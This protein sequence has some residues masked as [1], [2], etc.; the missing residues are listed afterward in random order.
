MTFVRRAKIGDLQAIQR[1]VELAYGSYLDRMPVPP[2]ALLRDYKRPVEG[3]EVDVLCIAGEVVGLVSLIRREDHVLLENL[4]V[5][6]SRQ[7]E[8]LGRRL[9]DH[10]EASALNDGLP[11]LRLYT[12][13][14]MHESLGFY[15]RCGF[16]EYDRRTED[17][18]ARVFLRKSVGAGDA[19]PAG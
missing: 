3:G 14:A 11:E 6:P 19:P 15:R 12:N 7:G 10:A 17:G 9:V 4:A 8:G 2:A 1:V 5:D 13:A 16:F 18:Y